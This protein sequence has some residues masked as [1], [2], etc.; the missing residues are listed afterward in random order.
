MNFIGYLVIGTDN[1]IYTLPLRRDHEAN[2]YGIFTP[3]SSGAADITLPT[4]YQVDGE[5]ITG[6]EVQSAELNKLQ[7]SNFSGIVK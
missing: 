4:N 7:S 5:R 3:P 2:K 1:D 6:L